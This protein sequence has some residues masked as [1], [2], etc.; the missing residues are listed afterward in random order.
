[1]NIFKKKN[2]YERYADYLKANEVELF[3]AWI[4]PEIL[5]ITG[6]TVTDILKKK[7]KIR[8]QLTME[9]ALKCLRLIN[10]QQLTIARISAEFNKVVEASFEDICQNDD[11][12]TDTF[13]AD[14]RYQIPAI[15]DICKIARDS[16]EIKNSDIV[17]NTIEEALN[18]IQS[19]LIMTVSVWDYALKAVGAIVTANVCNARKLVILNN[20][21]TE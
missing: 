13:I 16:A 2:H 5:N 17:P 9:D 21:K 1:M 14:E 11:V 4:N 8:K 15:C 7:T 10:A 19:L 18:S 12:S 3:T 20:I 6:L